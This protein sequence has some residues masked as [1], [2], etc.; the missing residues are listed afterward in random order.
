[1]SNLSEVF[2]P[3]STGLITAAVV[4][5]LIVLTKRWHGAVTFDTA[6]GVQ[7]FHDTP[8]PRIG[9]LAVL[10]GFW[11]AAGATPPPIRD[12][13]Y[14]LGIS[15]AVVF[16]AGLAEDMIKRTSTML[17][18]CAA[19]LSG[20]LF[21]IM[22]GYSVTRLDIPFIDHYLQRPAVSFALTAFMMASLINAVNMIDGF[23]GLAA[24]AVM[25]MLSAIAV[26]AWMANDYELALLAV[27]IATVLLGFLLVNFPRGYVFLGDGGAYFSGFLL[28]SLAVM[29][30]MRNPGISPWVSV[31]ILAY[32]V[33]EVI[34]AVL[35]KTIRHGHRP[36]EPDRLHLHMLIYR[37]FARRIARAANNEWLANPATSVLLWG[38]PMTSLAFVVFL[39]PTREW[40]LLA[41]SLQIVL[42]VSV[43][44]RSALLHRHRLLGIPKGFA[45]KRGGVKR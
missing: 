40:S 6:A 44:R 20:L 37:T 5:L 39:P 11:A 3:A 21:C 45:R 18:L 31:V 28:G 25:L 2:W 13:L 8:T 24:G 7:K 29:L 33:L 36:T 42:Y 43:Y 22:T 1:M 19:M 14:A 32:P 12:L 38:G 4:S 30:P 23:N 16:L 26:V 34:H 15:G 9:G 35:R 10:V 41:C 17:R 27:A